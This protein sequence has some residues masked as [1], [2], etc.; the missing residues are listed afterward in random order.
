MRPVT[1]SR[2]EDRSPSRTWTAAAWAAALA[3]GLG[4]APVDAQTLPLKRTFVG[5]LP[6]ACGSKRAAPAVAPTPAKAE[7]AR[8][9]FGL[10]QEAAV[11]GDHRAARDL[12]QQAAQLNG[13]DERLPYYLGRSLEEL[14]Q[15]REAVAQYCRYLALA[16][17]GFD[18]DDVR[19]RLDRLASG[20][21]GGTAAAT[22]AAGRRSVASSRFHTAVDLADRGKLPQ[23]EGALDDVIGQMPN[24]AEAYYD[25]GVLRARRN[26][27]GGAAAD[28]DRYVALRPDA[29]DAAAVRERVSQLRRA[30][31]SPGTAFMGGVVIPGFG[32]FYTG[33]PVLGLVVAGG[34]AGG[35]AYALATTRE[36]RTT[37]FTTPFGGTYE[38][39]DTVRVR[40][41]VAVGAAIAGG[42]ALLGAIEGYAFAQRRRADAARFADATMNGRG[43]R[44]L[45]MRL[46]PALTRADE[47]A[48]PRLGLALRGR[49]TF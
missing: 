34:V 42:A 30:A 16:P 36:P 8:R 19:G 43:N 37:V 17:T 1:R 7:E 13:T 40:N 46:E 49:L 4:A 3:L 28:F 23:A 33:R 24:A 45:A 44:S 15:P 26:D 14:Q 39:T 11:V 9:L 22:S 47:T 5:P 6:A 2:S 25:R 18:A 32:Q 29:E 31:T 21:K 10:G 41:H 12:F 20:G 38:Q 35:V 48:T 27:F